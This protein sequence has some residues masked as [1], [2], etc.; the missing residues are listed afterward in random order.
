[1][2]LGNFASEL[3]RLNPNLKVVNNREAST[4]PYAGIVLKGKESFIDDMG[5]ECA[6]LP[7]CAVN[8]AGLPRYRTIIDKT[9]RIEARSLHDTLMI[10]VGKGLIDR[11][12]AEKRFNIRLGQRIPPY[13]RKDWE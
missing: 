1:M 6:E 12:K 7:I 4:N 5:R 10:L 11:K 9:G 13:R 3:G 8:K 2:T